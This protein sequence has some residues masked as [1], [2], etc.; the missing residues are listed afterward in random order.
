MHNLA[1]VAPDFQG[2]PQTL[3]KYL[4]QDPAELLAAGVIDDIVLRLQNQHLGIGKG[5][6]CR[7]KQVVI[8]QMPA[9]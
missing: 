8:H 5:H 4:F 3:I 7:P 1:Q 9:L 6:L 2:N